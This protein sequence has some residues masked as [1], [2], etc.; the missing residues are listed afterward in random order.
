VRLKKGG[1]DV[2]SSALPPAFHW[3]HSVQ[4]FLDEQS[5][6]KLGIKSKSEISKKAHKK[7][8]EGALPPETSSSTVPFPPELPLASSALSESLS[9]HPST[10]QRSASMVFK[11]RKSLKNPWREGEKLPQHRCFDS[12][13][14]K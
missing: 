11:R 8:R 4:I 13:L 12:N 3:Q 10:H 14:R 9:S 1:E 2:E 7:G 5:A 6:T